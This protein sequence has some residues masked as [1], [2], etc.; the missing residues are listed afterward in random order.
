[1]AAID[2]A[3]VILYSACV[4]CRNGVWTEFDKL[5]AGDVCDFKGSCLCCEEQVCC[6][7]D[8]LTK[9]DFLL[10]GVPEGKI[11]QI[12]CG[13]CAV[14]LQ[15]PELPKILAGQGH[16]CCC[17]QSAAFPFDDANPLMCGI[18]FVSLFP[19]VG[20]AMT[21]ADAKKEAEIKTDAV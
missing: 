11:C 21:W 10:P 16:C 1:M 19:N 5:I 18:C 4:C 17:A 14:A 7:L 3:K 8:R 9:S 13:C 15:Q 6:Q 2:D 20:V 12:G